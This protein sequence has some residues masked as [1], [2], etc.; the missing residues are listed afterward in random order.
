[1]P[2]FLE[3]LVVTLKT[4]LRKP[5]TAE[6]PDPEKRIQPS[7]RYMGFPAL[8]WD[9]DVAE[10]YCTGCMVCI[11]NCPTQCMTAKMQDNPKFESGESRR[12]KIIEDFE[13]NL[14]RC[15]LCAICVDVCNFDA[16]EMSHEHELSKYERDGNRA[17]L[18]KLLELGKEFQAE[19][20]WQP[21][22]PEKNSGVPKTNARPAATAA[23]NAQ[24]VEILIN[25]G[26]MTKE[27]RLA[28]ARARAQA[29]RQGATAE[30]GA[31]PP[32]TKTNMTKEERLAAARARAQAKRDSAD[33]SPADAKPKPVLS[34]SLIGSG[35]D[36]VATKSEAEG[37]EMTKEERV[38]A[39]RARA[40]AKRE[41]STQDSNDAGQ[42]AVQT[43]NVNTDL[44][45]PTGEMTKE[46]RVAAARARAKAKR[47]PTQSENP[48]A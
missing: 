48:E 40:K 22:N 15:I 30:I 36:S 42:T 38:A 21:T 43:D 6:Y 34:D 23:A 13:I 5:V 16:I 28:A 31:A 20:S 26:G 17:D 44:N 47:Q 12:R 7:E 3:G 14:G 18:P 33:T 29:K 39:A 35:L 19:T 9:N 32:D 10:P 45:N 41:S 24:P 37:A 11:R 2:K 1:M 8:L 27:E 25:V 4:A 46:E